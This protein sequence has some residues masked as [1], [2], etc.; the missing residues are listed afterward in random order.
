MLFINQASLDT[1]FPLAGVGCFA[2]VILYLFSLVTAVVGLIWGKKPDCRPCLLL[3]G[4]Q[5]AAAVG[6]TVL[7]KPY[8]VFVLPPVV[9]LTVL[10]LMG[11]RK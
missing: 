6:I 10:Y 2:A 7:L 1:S 9:I 4:V 8:A 11:A 5:L 3:G